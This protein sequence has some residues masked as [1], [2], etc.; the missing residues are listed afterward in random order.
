M[1]WEGADFKNDQGEDLVASRDGRATQNREFCWIM[2]DVPRKQVPSENN[3]PVARLGQHGRRE[4][5][6]AR[7]RMTDLMNTGAR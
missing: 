4:N 1:A 7:R 2:G 5:Q 6:S 3:E